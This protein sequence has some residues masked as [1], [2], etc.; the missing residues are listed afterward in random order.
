MRTLSL[1]EKNLLS[2]L[3]SELVHFHLLFVIYLIKDE[4]GLVPKTKLKEG[5]FPPAKVSSF[6]EH[7]LGRSE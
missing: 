5:S 2:A 4:S 1:E 7:G 6:S 3:S